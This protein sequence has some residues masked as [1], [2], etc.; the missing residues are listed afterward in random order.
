MNFD[1]WIQ[2]SDGKV[3][4]RLVS[5]AERIG[6]SYSVDDAGRF[7]FCDVETLERGKDHPDVLA[8][9][10]EFGSEWIALQMDASD[11]LQRCVSD[12]VERK[13]RHLVE[14]TEI[15]R[16]VIVDRFQCPAEW[17]GAQV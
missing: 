8:L 10:E 14:T 7:L 9:D 16:F 12:L 15:G 6:L 1:S 11:E 2:F 5:V 3:Q 13:I 17:S 4:R